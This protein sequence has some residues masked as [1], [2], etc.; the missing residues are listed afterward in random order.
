MDPF[1]RSPVS[2]ASAGLDYREIKSHSSLLTNERVAILFYMLDLN[3]MNLNTYYKEDNLL[4]TKANLYQIYKNIR[5]IIRSHAHVRI[6]LDLETKVP[7]A[8]TIDVA[9]DIIDQMVQYCQFNGFTYKRCYAIAQQLNSVEISLRDV[10]Q[11]FN[12]FF[13]TDLKQKPD[14]F[15]ATDKYKQMA[16]KLTVEKLRE[17]I[18][19]NNKIDFDRIALSEMS[20]QK[21]LENM[22]DEEEDKDE[23]EEEEDAEE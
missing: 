9:F 5:P 16:D 2:K 1:Q 20:N 17:V 8:Y 4:K 18:G 22:P 19:K 13:R 14:V 10:L 3:S 6:A 21:M 23:P 7:G 12:Y 11:H 15:L